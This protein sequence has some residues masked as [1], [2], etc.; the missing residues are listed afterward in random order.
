M[1]LKEED[2]DEEDR[3]SKKR[4]KRMTLKEENEDEED[5]M[6]QKR[7]TLTED[8]SAIPRLLILTMETYK[9]RMM[10]SYAR[11][12]RQ[13]PL[14]AQTHP[15]ICRGKEELFITLSYF[16]NERVNYMPVPL[17]RSWVKC[18]ESHSCRSAC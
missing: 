5:R 3:M 10:S 15:H 2:E 6:S 4:M 12:N 1:T 8:G 13:P 14:C 16:H 7:K 11:W 17:P 9:N 18:A